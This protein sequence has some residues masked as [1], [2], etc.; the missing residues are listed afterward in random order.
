MR[1]LPRTTC[2]ILSCLLMGNSFAQ[3]PAAVPAPPSG[4]SP[5]RAD[6][7]LKTVALIMGEPNYSVDSAYQELEEGFYSQPELLPGDRMFAPISEIVVNLGGEVQL[8]TAQ[9][10]GTF[11]L[12]GK[13]L[14]LQ[15]G[16]LNALLDGKPVQTD[17]APQWRNGNLWV[18]LYWVFDQFGAYTKW[19]KTRQ[20][21]TAS[22]VLPV[23]KK[24]ASLAKGGPVT[25]RT[26]LTQTPDFWASA[27]GTKVADVVLGYQ[28]SDGG[29]PKLENDTNLTIP[30]NRSALTGFKSKS[31]IDNDATTKQIVVL[32]R[33]YQA[34]RQERFR[35]GVDKGLD[36]LMAAQLPNGGWQ[37]NWPNPLGYKARITFNDDAMA[38]VLEVLRDVAS[39]SRD[40]SFV[41]SVQARRAHAAY[42]AGIALILKAQ[43]RVAGKKTG[44][45]GQY[46]EN[47]LQPAMGRAFE[48]ASIS[49]G[50]SVN[51]VR[52]LMSIEKPSAEVQQAVQDA[53]AWLDSAKITGVKRVRKEDRTLEYGF[54]FVMENTGGSDVTWARFYALETGRP[55]FAARDSKPR[56]HFEDVSYERR[57]KYNWYTSEAATLLSTDYPAWIKRQ[58][59]KSVL[60]AR[61]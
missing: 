44:W 17:I 28:N 50:E 16:Q 57:V 15:A 35:N 20:R 46:D 9:Q 40:F 13:T 43:I 51:V 55:L 33:A 48:L 10:A 5:A 21:F 36:Y 45:G 19:D 32:A 26:L 4:S 49:G 53:V 29:W 24:I 59:L 6:G 52:F 47:T 2:V 61:R 27:E 8:D 39:L 25:E 54:D 30:V 18:S 38:N 7:V 60:G 3:T 23:S 22:L 42:D 31:T 56:A 37:Q 34:T 14:R 58:G 41:T 11:S 1:I 12:A